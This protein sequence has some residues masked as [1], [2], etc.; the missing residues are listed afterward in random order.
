MNPW[1]LSVAA[2]ACYGISVTNYAA[3]AGNDAFI[4]EMWANEGLAILEA[5]MVMANLVY[6]DFEPQVQNYGDVVN[7]RRPGNFAISR[8]RDGDTLV[9]QEANATNVRVP[10][11]QWFYTNFVI[12]DGEA[13]MSFQDLVDVYLVPGMQ[14]IAKSVDR[15]ILGRIHAYLTGSGNRAGKLGGLTAGNSQDYVLEA[16]QRLNENLAPMQGRNLVLSPAAETALLKNTMFVKANERGDGGS[17]L[18]NATLG[19]I[20]GFN[21]YLD[22]NVNSF[23]FGGEYED[24]TCTSGPHAAGYASALNV[25]ITG[26]AGEYV[27]VA[28]NDQ[29][30]YMTDATTGAIVLNEALKYPVQDD[31]AVR[32][33]K[34]CDVD[35]SA[36]PNTTY[37]V[38]YTKPIAL[39]GYASETG[40]QAGQLIAFGQSTSRR[41][42]TILEVTRVSDTACKVLLDRPLEV[43]V[44]DGNNLAFPGPQGSLNW[45][46]HREAIALVSRPLAMPN[47]RMGVLTQVGVHNGISMRV[48]MQYDI[49]SGGTVVNLDLLCG[50]AVLDSRL[51]VPLLG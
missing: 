23:T 30:T 19:R 22:Q 39:D 50:V 4:P 44:A 15:A 36:E 38:G 2:V 34:A 27:V 33:Y 24:L 9:P 7:T 12:K 43:A 16:R 45:A 35:A 49:N 32:H 20:L 1:Y 18:E 21:T 31:C 11:D 51:C 13:S 47:N 46:F 26:F 5:N 14:T 29:P 28:G 37:A 8:K 42:Y 3:D 6:R 10:L 48:A 40:P 17:A 25:A 41:V